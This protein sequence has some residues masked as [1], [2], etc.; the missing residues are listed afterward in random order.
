MGGAKIG[1]TLWVAVPRWDEAAY[2]KVGKGGI[3][4][5]Q[6]HTE[7]TNTQCVAIADVAGVPQHA[8]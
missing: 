6:D 2:P 1:G 8:T 7:P 5:F 3:G 4:S